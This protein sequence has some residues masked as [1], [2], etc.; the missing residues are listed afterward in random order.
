MAWLP[1]AMKTNLQDLSS[2]LGLPRPHYINYTLFWCQ[3]RVS[4][5]SLQPFPKPTDNK[6]IQII[7]NEEEVARGV[8]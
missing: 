1:R 8:A 3:L 5:A 7:G 2:H 4:L 6:E